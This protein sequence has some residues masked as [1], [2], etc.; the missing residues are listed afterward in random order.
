MLRVHPRHALYPGGLARPIAVGNCAG[1]KS[2][3]LVSS[4][5]DIPGI[6]WGVF[7]FFYFL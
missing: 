2:Q 5:S 1:E 4:L 6:G 3:D 7:L